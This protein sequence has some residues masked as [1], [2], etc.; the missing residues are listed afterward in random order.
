MVMMTCAGEIWW[1]DENGEEEPDWVKQER[2]NFGKHRDR[3]QDGYLDKEEVAYMIQPP[4]YDPAYAESQHLLQQADDNKVCSYVVPQ[5]NS[6][7]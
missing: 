5:S 6:M 1:G 2:E 3:N 4:G 7:V